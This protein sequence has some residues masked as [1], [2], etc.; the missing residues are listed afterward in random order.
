MSI[1]IEVRST[2]LKDREVT[3]RSSGRV[4]RFKEQEAWAHVTNDKGE[5]QPYPEKITVSL[6]RGRDTAYEP[7][8]YTLHPASFY[9]GK[10]GNLEMSTRLVPVSPSR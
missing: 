10:F 2:E 3:Q 4:F 1:V 9:V 8:S 6:P 7:G 5:K